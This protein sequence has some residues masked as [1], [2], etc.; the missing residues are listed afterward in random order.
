MRATKDQVDFAVFVVRR[1]AARWGRSTP[2]T[3]LLLEGSGILDDYVFAAYDVLHT[4]GAE[5]LVDDVTDLA[6]ERG[7]LV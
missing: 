1:L 3:Y 5:A 4:Q 6:R 7:V 2:E